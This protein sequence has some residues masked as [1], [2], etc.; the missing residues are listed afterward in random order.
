MIERIFL[1]NDQD[2]IN[3]MF[4]R[5]HGYKTISTILQD[6]LVAKNSG[7][8]S[9][10]TDNNDIDNSTGDNAQDKDELIIKILKILV[11]WPAVTKNKIASA[12]LEEVV[13]DIQTNNENS[14]NNDEINQ[15]C[16]SL[17]DR[18]SKLE[19]AYRIP[20]QESVPTNN[21]AAATTT[22]T[23]TG[24]TTSASPFERI[25]SHTPEVGG[26]NTPSSTSQQQQQQ[27]SRDAGLP[28]NWRS[29]FDKTLVDIIIIILLLKKLPGKDLWVHYH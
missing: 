18:W 13:K 9:E 10:T 21:A 28:E 1:S 11:S 12:N 20:K 7:K 17:L 2:D 8:E 24:T 23:A 6:L 22:A 16:T 26:T 19:M 27:N 29:A 3:V 5:F 25:S 4:V 14:N 15:L